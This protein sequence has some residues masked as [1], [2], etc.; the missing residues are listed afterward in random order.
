MFCEIL[1]LCFIPSNTIKSKDNIQDTNLYNHYHHHHSVD[2]IIPW[3]DKFAF[4]ER[5]CQSF[6][7]WLGWCDYPQATIRRRHENSLSKGLAIAPPPFPRLVVVGAVPVTMFVTGAI[8]NLEFIVLRIQHMLFML[9]MLCVICSIH[10]IPIIHQDHPIHQTD[11][12]HP[13][14]HLWS[15]TETCLGGFPLLCL[16]T[17]RRSSCTNVRLVE[18][19]EER[20]GRE[21]VCGII[22]VREELDNILRMSLLPRAAP[23][24]E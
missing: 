12:I 2:W 23:D 6:S 8:A 7:S 15:D 1:P 20:L 21:E 17:R 24:D 16:K 19:E 14:T 18:E 10:P 11:P 13:F 3:G 22:I 4:W 9:Y 5:S